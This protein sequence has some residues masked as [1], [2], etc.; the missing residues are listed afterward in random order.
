MQDLIASELLAERYIGMFY[1]NNPDAVAEYL[2]KESGVL[3]PG[4]EKLA[5]IGAMLSKALMGGATK[6]A[7][8]AAVGGALLGALGGAL[9]RGNDLRN[10]GRMSNA[11]R[12]SLAAKGHAARKA[13][14]KSGLSVMSP[15]HAKASRDG[16]AAQR[17]SHGNKSGDFRR[18]QGLKE[19]LQLFGKDLGRSAASGAAAGGLAGGGVRTGVNL[20]K[21]RAMGQKIDK[22]LPYVGA[23]LAGTYLLAKA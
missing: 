8:R 23:G 18:P 9:K 3:E 16:N 22:A 5:S 12:I 17:W 20:A 19:N 2:V 11:G 21:R 15:A 14:S 6:G 4:N 13:H 10:I 7:G 1:D